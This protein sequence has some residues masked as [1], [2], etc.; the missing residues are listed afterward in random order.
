MI[1]DKAKINQSFLFFLYPSSDGGDDD[2]VKKKKTLRET[3]MLK[4]IS[5]ITQDNLENN[6]PSSQVLLSILK[7]DFLEDNSI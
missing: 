6:T 1:C 4:T 3:K 5:L 7:N 2:D